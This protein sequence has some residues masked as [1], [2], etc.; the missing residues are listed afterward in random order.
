[1]LYRTL[2]SVLQLSREVNQSTTSSHFGNEDGNATC[3]IFARKSKIQSALAQA[4]AI[5]KS[6]A[7]IEFNLDGT[8]VT[9]NRNFL[10]ALGY[11]LD[12]IKGKHHSMFVEQG[13]ARERGLSRILGQAQSRRIPGR[14]VQAV[15]QG[16]PRNLDPGVL[17]SDPRCRRQAGRRHQVR[18]RH[19]RAEDPEHGGRRQ[20]RGDGPRPGRDRIQHGRHHR[21]RQ[22]RIFS[23]RS[24]TRWP[25]SRASTTACSWCRTIAT[26]PPI[27]NSGPS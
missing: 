25:K 9:A 26:A 3:S 1:M 15:R 10:D 16:R 18:H 23:A 5:S 12:E 21:H 4:D 2:N 27:A 13:R 11:T 24:A 20:D 6:Q 19:H 17:Q 14:A 7:V 8:I 22:S